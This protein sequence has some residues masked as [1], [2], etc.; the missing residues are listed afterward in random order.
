[1]HRYCGFD[2]G[3]EGGAASIEVGEAGRIGKADGLE[4]LHAGGGRS[5]VHALGIQLRMGV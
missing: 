5:E 3:V 4:G 1:M 2:D